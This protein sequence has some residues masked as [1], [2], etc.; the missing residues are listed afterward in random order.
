VF[1]DRRL[2]AKAGIALLVA[3]LR[4]W[5]TVAPAV[6]AQLKRW[7]HRAQ[8]ISD[9]T[10]RALALEKLAQESF[11]A[12]VAATLATLAPR[13]YRA[14]VVEAI[15][16]YEVMYDYLDGLTEQPTTDP[17][18]DGRELFRAFTDAVEIP[19]VAIGGYYA[20]H[21][22]KDDGGYLDALACAVQRALSQLP[23][24][25]AVTIACQQAA[26]RCAE[27]Q[28]RAHA[29]DQLG[30]TQ[31]EQWAHQQVAT[32]PLGWQE[33]LAG[34]ASSVL[35]VHA[36]IAAAADIH[37]TPDEAHEID[38]L[39]LSICALSTLLDGLVDHERDEQ[40]GHAGYLRYYD[41]PEQISRDLAS[42]SRHAA[43]HAAPLRHGAYH[44]MTLAGVASYYLSAPS[45]NSQFAKPLTQRITHELRPLI[46]PTLAV[47]RAWRLAK[48]ARRALQH[49]PG[50]R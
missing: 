43:T 31:V 21:Q 26:T 37:T 8:R 1:C 47:M 46:T 17:L 10:L 30:T 15:V 12:E 29:A 5:P 20:H 18:R 45:A 44:L 4:F 24:A 11:N 35:T 3:N 42:A 41:N 22:P 32:G 7:E 13:K 36:L 14:R 27:A 39:Y 48:N 23:A 2:V 49:R 50:D 34:A 19:T 6:G 38:A 33:L 25:A 16:A 9:P 28:V 40:T